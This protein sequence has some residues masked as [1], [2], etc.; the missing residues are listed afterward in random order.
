[1]FDLKT[2]WR[3]YYNIIGIIL[4]QRDF[5]SASTELTLTRHRLEADTE[6]KLEKCGNNSYPSS[7]WDLRSYGNYERVYKYVLSR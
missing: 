7:I 5:S 3:Y 4:S 6:V 1:M 2:V